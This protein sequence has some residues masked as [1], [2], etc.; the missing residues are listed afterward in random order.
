MGDLHINAFV[1]LCSHDIR[2]EA[3]NTT[4][5]ITLL[6]EFISQWAWS[7]NK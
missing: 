7:D 6:I 4:G 5:K 3:M 2:D 1:H